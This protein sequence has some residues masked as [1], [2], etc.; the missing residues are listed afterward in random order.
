MKLG[1]DRGPIK[2]SASY[3]KGTFT[4]ASISSHTW[5]NS[6]FPTSITTTII[7]DQGCGLVRRTTLIHVEDPIRRSFYYI[8]S[9]TTCNHRKQGAASPGPSPD[10]HSLSCSSMADGLNS[11]GSATASADASTSRSAS[12]SIDSQPTATESAEKL[13]SKAHRRRSSAADSHPRVTSSIARRTSLGTR[14]SDDYKRQSKND[15]DD[16]ELSDSLELEALSDDDSQDDEEAGLTGKDKRRSRR[17][18]NSALGDRIAGV[19]TVTAEEKKEAD[20]HVLRNMM[21]NCSLIGLWYCFSLSI[22][23]VCLLPSTCVVLLTV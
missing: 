4:R 14:E 7:A 21:I 15:G 22:S 5:F 8:Q 12:S 16:S 23:L 13:G 2:L 3:S 9:E 18:K 11:H 6:S 17:R 1:Q 20:V 10:S 19:D